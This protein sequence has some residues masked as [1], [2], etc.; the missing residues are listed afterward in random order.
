MLK[1]ALGID[2]YHLF[3]YSNGTRVALT[4]LDHYPQQLRSV[5]LD[6]VWPREATWTEG[7]PTTLANA[8]HGIIRLCQQ[9]QDCNAK[10]PELALHTRKLAE[11]FLKAPQQGA[12]GRY[13]SDSVLAAY[14]MDSGY[15]KQA[16]QFIPEQLEQMYRGDYQA[17]EQF[18]LEDYRST[19]AHIAYLCHDEIGFEDKAMIRKNAGDDPVARLAISSLERYYDACAGF[20]T[21]K[22]PAVEAEPV[23]RSC[24]A[25]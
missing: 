17:L 14:L 16:I 5:V 9:N 22:G 12:D 20:E 25:N 24:L 6:S 19:G 21:D 3:G 10:Y 1:T 11:R 15:A 18:E 4:A 13:Y 8:V 23:D 7:T 2:D